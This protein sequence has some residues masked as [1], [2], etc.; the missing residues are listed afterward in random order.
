MESAFWQ[1]ESKRDREGRLNESQREDEGRRGES[2][3]DRGSRGERERRDRIQLLIRLSRYTSET[4][5]HNAVSSLC[6]LSPPPHPPSRKKGG[7][8]SNTINHV[9]NIRTTHPVSE[10]KVQ[11]MI[12]F[13][14]RSGYLYRCVQVGRRRAIISEIISGGV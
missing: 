8:P 1:R 4:H 2:R 11:T 12:L 14:Y 7:R 5:L 9:Q 3:G 13:S 6:L 10:N